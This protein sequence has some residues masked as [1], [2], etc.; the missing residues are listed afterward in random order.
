MKPTAYLTN[1]ARGGVVDEDALLQALR[2]KRIAGAA[3]DVF[4]TEPLPSDH[5]FW[6]MDNV[7]ITPHVGGFNDGYAKAAMPILTE[8][9]R[10]VLAGKREEMINIVER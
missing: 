2:D 7:M 6:E 5:P 10:L 4:V 9:M 8:N 3:L 1:L